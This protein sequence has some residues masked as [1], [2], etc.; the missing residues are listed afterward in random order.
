[1][2]DLVMQVA[3]GWDYR[4]RRVRQGA[5]IYR[6]LEGMEGF[7]R[8]RSTSMRVRRRRPLTGV[9]RHGRYHGAGTG[10]WA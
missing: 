5:V 6:A 2:T 10:L 3:L 1:M 7:K 9:R 8:R 4:G